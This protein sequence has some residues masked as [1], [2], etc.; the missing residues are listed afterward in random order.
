MD[1]SESLTFNQLTQD[2]ITKLKDAFQMLDEDEDGL[3]SRGDLTKI[4]ATL[5]KTLTDEE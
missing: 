5:G 3:I 2:Y 1:H 4:Y